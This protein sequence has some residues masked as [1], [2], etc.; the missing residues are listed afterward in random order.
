MTR[1]TIPDGQPA[2]VSADVIVVGAGPTGL[3]SALLLAYRGH[4]VA[5]IEKWPQPYALPRAVGISHESLRALQAAGVI[6]DLLPQLLFTSDGSRV[7]EVCAADGEIL[8]TRRDKAESVSGWPERASF[9]QP[10]LEKTLNAR[11]ADHPNIQLCRGW[12]VTQ[13]AAKDHEVLVEARRYPGGGPTQLQ[14]HGR[15]VLG[16]D[17]A[18][19]VVADPDWADVTDIGF[20]YDWLVVDIILGQP[21]TFSPDLGQILGPPRPTTLVRGGPGRRRWEFMRLPGESMDELNR[22]ETA[23]RLLAPFAVYPGEAVLERHAVYTFRGRWARRWHDGRA[24]IAGDAAH[25]M[26]PFLGEGFNSGVRDAL[27]VTWRLDL[28]LRGLASA[29]LLDSY[30]SERIGHVS[31]IVRQAVELGRMICVTDPAEA[32]LR[33]GRLREIR[34]AGGN[35]DVR[36][37]W[38]LGPGTWLGHDQWAG[39]LGLQ[40]RIRL[41]G[42]IGRFDDLVGYGKFVLVGLDGD[43]ARHLSPAIRRRWAA[44][45][46]VV[47]SFGA[48]SPIADVDGTYLDWFTAR[49]AKVAVFRP[50]FYVFGTGAS[51]ADSGALA[52]EVLREIDNETR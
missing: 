1:V 19:S 36:A 14:A 18:N 5:L 42:E 27:A 52:A 33:N 43:P 50:D 22:P 34:D 13:V 2:E 51:L 4:A 3:L 21:R 12:D 35:L 23:W 41:A 32:Q 24:I 28:V 26:P 31:Q 9:C 20:A 17:G 7:R 38:R 40:G 10:E 39:Y 44:I 29:A 8:A 30:S 47:T 25:L 16:C 46:G 37:Q 48:N 15:Y 49:N 45:G 11:A 6:D